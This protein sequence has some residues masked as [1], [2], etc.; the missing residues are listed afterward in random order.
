MKLAC[1]SAL[2]LSQFTIAVS[3]AGGRLDPALF[4]APN[5]PMWVQK[6]HHWAIAIFTG[7]F[8]L[9]T[10]PV[11]P[12][13]AQQ[14]G[15]SPIAGTSRSMPQRKWRKRWVASWVAMAVVNA[16]DLRSS[17]GLRESNPLLRGPS[18]HLS[19]ERA[20][21]IKSALSAGAFAAQWTAIR[22]RPAGNTCKSFVLVNFA[23]SGTLAGIAARNLALRS[24]RV[25]QTPAS[26]TLP[27]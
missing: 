21:L 5:N 4:M 12:A 6:R 13:R 3:A 14:D 10:V 15:A 24:A 22:R 19:T 25:H 23:A 16:L 1:H 8:L 26:P 17:L 11:S 9:S 7:L 2:L 27:E 18:G 20:I